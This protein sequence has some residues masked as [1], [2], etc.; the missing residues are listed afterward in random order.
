MWVNLLPPTAVGAYGDR[1]DGYTVEITKPDASKETL[2]PFTSDP[3]GNYYASY[4]PNQVGEYK[5][6]F[7]FP[8]DTVTG[9]PVPPGGYYFGTGVYIGDKILASESAPVYVT[10]QEDLIEDY[11]ETPLPTGYWTRPI[12]GANREWYKV[13]G[14]WLSGVHNPG[15]INPYSTGPESAHIMWARP[16]WDGGIMGGN[17]GDIGYYTGMSYETFGLFPPII[18][19][20]RLY[21]NVMT[22]PRAGWYC[23]DLRTG[24]EL[25]FHN[26]TGPIAGQTNKY[27]ASGNDFDFT[28]ALV[29]GTLSFGQVL[30]IE[31]PNQHGGL[32][33]LWS[34][35]QMGSVWGGTGASTTWNMFDAY[36]GNYICS[37]ANVSMAGTNVYGK[38]GSILYYNIANLGTTTNPKYYLQVWNTTQAIWYRTAWTGNQFW[39]WR[40]Y[41][42]QTFDGRYGFSL[43]A[44]IAATSLPGTIREVV[45]GDHIIGGTS[46]VHNST[47]IQKGTLWCLSLKAGQA[48]T[49]LWTREFT[50]PLSTVEDVKYVSLPGIFNYGYM[51]GPTV[52]SVNGVFLFEESISMKRWGFDLDTMQQ[53]WESEPEEQWNFYG[54]TESI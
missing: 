9:L 52:D 35:G 46:G 43:N 32:P 14:N 12:Y 50:P 1:W 23:V 30:D 36:T 34:T 45:E 17:T 4:T 39:M 48:G 49:L 37:I 16:F 10:V 33:Y 31:L 22:N 44:S 28:G 53:L 27:P 2:G 13:A 19:N 29:G 42:N 54:L 47:Y 20:G 25:Y 21:Y 11:E 3:V 40:P 41:W 18:V 5:F 15:Y 8:G 26:T 6:V 38:D 51:S 7:K 24:E